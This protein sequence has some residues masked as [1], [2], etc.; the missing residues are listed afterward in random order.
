MSVPQARARGG[1]GR[2]VRLTDC[3]QARARGGP[4]GGPEGG[5]GENDGL[6]PS[7]SQKGGPKP[8][9]EGDHLVLTTD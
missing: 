1:R 7:Q 2:E 9:P 6:S 3:P 8:E 5:G 4:E